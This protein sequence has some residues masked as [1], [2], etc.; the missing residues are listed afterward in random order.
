MNCTAS[1]HLF[2]TTRL[3]LAFRRDR[4]SKQFSFFF[5]KGPAPCLNSNI[6]Q[7]CR[8]R[9][10]SAYGRAHPP[11]FCSCQDPIEKNTHF[12]VEILVL[13]VFS[14]TLL[15]I[16]LTSNVL[17]PGFPQRWRNLVAFSE[18][19]EAKVIAYPSH[20]WKTIVAYE[21]RRFFSHFG[22]DPVGIARAAL[23]LSALGGGSTITQQVIVFSELTHAKCLLF[24]S[25]EVGFVDCYVV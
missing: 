17:L 12:I 11:H 9:Q 10:N 19:A 23:S 24:L 6:P 5:Y 18:E 13:F 25:S 8:I 20:L 22:V 14:L 15:C 2:F 1:N 7:T 21:D 3:N 4:L 16:R